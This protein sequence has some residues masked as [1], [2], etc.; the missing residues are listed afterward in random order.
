M[1]AVVKLLD[2]LRNPVSRTPLG[3]REALLAAGALLIL[4]V[5]VYAPHVVRG[6]WYLDDWTHV[7]LVSHT[8]D[9]LAAFEAMG[10][11]SYRPGLALSITV[12]YLIAG[13]GQWPYLAIGVALAG[14]QSWLF[15]LVLRR[16]RLHVA[17]A[18]I[19]AALFLVLPCIDATRLWIAAFPIQVAGSLYLMGVL[20][21][22]YGL[23]QSSRRRRAALHAGAVTLYVMSIL[24]YELIAGLVVVTP[25]LYATIGPWRAVAKRLL[26]DYAGIALALAFLAP[27]AADARGA[28]T[29]LG[30][31]WDRAVQMWTP[32]EQVF[33]SLI[34]WQEVLG[35][36]IGLVLLA[37]GAVGA[38][39]EIRR[40][41][42]SG[43]GFKR[44]GI[45]GVISLIFAGAGLVL[46]L[47]A[48][49]YFIPRT[50]GLGNRVSAYAA[51]GAVLLLVALAVIALGGIGA[52]FRRPRA[53]I[54]AALALICVAM[55]TLTVR[56]LRQQDPWADSWA[57]Q[58]AVVTAVGSALGDKIYTASAVVTFGH[59]TFILPDDVS[60]FAY[61]WDLDG[62]LWQVYDRFD[63]AGHPW[64]A[65]GQ[66]GP[67][68]VIFP[69]GVGSPDGSQP[70]GYAGRL[71]F[72][73][74]RT[75]KA[76][77]IPNRQACDS[78][79]A[80]LAG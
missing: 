20:A 8:S 47:P 72:V 62:A 53:G 19:A 76:L 46:L 80:A 73:D 58:K 3:L 6:G 10:N 75:A 66:C 26:A 78:A 11:L 22:L 57:E 16:L 67:A 25:I 68:G 70:F 45:V 44:W 36:R 4:A 74:T 55:V 14:L 12:F 13:D 69:G 51:L 33:R 5:G 56:E 24:T 32:A 64:V 27:R 42:A 9:P 41:T 17:V 15:Y 77:R 40:R 63:V 59:T 71:F 49:P 31:L 50:T 37:I 39:L 28:D 29:S 18:A 21:A 7:A 79:V 43:D 35:G 65:G 38:G 2:A 23:G 48:D 30:F 1:L 52:L 61:S 54:A 60:V 34:P